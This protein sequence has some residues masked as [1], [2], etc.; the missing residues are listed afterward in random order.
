MNDCNELT[1]T[2]CKNILNER[3][4]KFDKTIYKRDCNFL[5]FLT[6]LVSNTNYID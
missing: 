3:D 6:V 5:K 1:L 2:L 4:F